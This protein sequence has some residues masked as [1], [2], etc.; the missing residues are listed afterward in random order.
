M[1]A[2]PAILTDFPLVNLTLVHLSGA[3]GVSS[4]IIRIEAPPYHLLYLIAVPPSRGPNNW[5]SMRP[6]W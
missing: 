1:N 3:K 2:P 4:D 5:P 6:S